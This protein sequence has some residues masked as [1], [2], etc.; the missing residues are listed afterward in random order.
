MNEKQYK[1]CQHFVQHLA[2]NQR[3]IFCVYCGHCTLG[4]SKRK[5]PDAKACEHYISGPSPENA[6]VTKEYLSKELL[7][8]MLQLELLP[9]IEER[10]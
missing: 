1:N 9:E 2:L 8:Y 4:K 3:R 7:Q 5:Q 10:G 6:F